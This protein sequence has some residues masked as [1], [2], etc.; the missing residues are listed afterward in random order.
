[1]Q[2]KQPFA[3][4]LGQKTCRNSIG[5]DIDCQ[6]IRRCNCFNGHASNTSRPRLKGDNKSTATNA[7]IH[8]VNGNNIL[9]TRFRHTNSQIRSSRC[10]TFFGKAK[11][12]SYQ[13][14]IG[15]RSAGL[16]ILR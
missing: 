14:P 6:F 7:V 5:I 16:K 15:S 3:G 4:R 11:R 2:Q 9:I 13:R 1:M 10:C 12:L 8:C